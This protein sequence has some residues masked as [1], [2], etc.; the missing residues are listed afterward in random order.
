MTAESIHKV[1]DIVSLYGDVKSI[2]VQK[3]SAKQKVE[4]AEVK[5]RVVF[6]PKAKA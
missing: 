6:V 4:V 3:E 2:K 5:I 1:R